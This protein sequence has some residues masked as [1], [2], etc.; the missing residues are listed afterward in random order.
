MRQERSA[1]GLVIRED[2]VLLVKDRYGRWTLPK[3]HVE[4]GETDEEAALREIREET[5]V[6]GKIL[7]PLGVTRYVF[8]KGKR[9]VAKTV[10]YYEVAYVDG[11]VA[12]QKGEILEAQWVPMEKMVE[13]VDYDNVRQ[14]LRNL[15]KKNGRDG[16]I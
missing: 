8:G 1:G 11:E 13:M 3:G 2:E 15:Y 7:R 5:G 16:E 10:V 14:L 9:R 4:P 12:P 6:R